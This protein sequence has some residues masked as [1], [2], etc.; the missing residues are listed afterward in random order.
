MVDI[1][2]Q[3][4]LKFNFISTCQNCQSN[5]PRTNQETAWDPHLAPP[6]RRIALDIPCD[7]IISDVACYYDRVCISSVIGGCVH[8]VKLGH[9]QLQRIWIDKPNC[10]TK[11][12]PIKQMQLISDIFN[13]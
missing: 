2:T 11:E 7:V 8:A 1:T 13:W 5:R 9:A 12:K 6:I 4:V 3:K 10:R